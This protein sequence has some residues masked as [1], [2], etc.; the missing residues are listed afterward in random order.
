LIF[1]L[2][3][4]R[5]WAV[6]FMLGQWAHALTDMGDTVGTMLFF[7]FTTH[8]FAVGAWAYA[9]QTGRFNDAGAY[10]S[11][12]GFVWDAVWIVLAT[13]GWRVFTR[14]YFEETVAA[15]DPIWTWARAALPMAV[16][17]A[18]YR[19]SYFYGVTRW[20]AWVIWA[21]VVNAYPLDLSWGGPYWVPALTASLPPVRAGPGRM[22]FLCPGGACCC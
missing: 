1:L 22:A 8:H 19:A 14:S 2:T 6:S 13:M 15:G 11:G 18:F 17:L 16:V 5:I 12:L 4:R 10:F 21:H 9:G 3:R 20:T 7:P